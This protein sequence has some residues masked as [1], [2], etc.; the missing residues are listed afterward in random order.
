MGAHCRA[1]AVGKRRR[2]RWQVQRLLLAGATGVMHSR[3]VVD[4]IRRRVRRSCHD[5]REAVPIVIFAAA[6]GPGELGDLIAMV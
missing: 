5:A 4:G 6:V 3:V 1:G 2:H